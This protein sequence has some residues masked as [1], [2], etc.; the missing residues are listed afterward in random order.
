MQ[1]TVKKLLKNEFNSYKSVNQLVSHTTIGLP[2]TNLASNDPKSRRFGDKATCIDL[3]RLVI[4]N[5]NGDHRD[6]V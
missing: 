3:E 6:N 4:S 2:E 1:T 5:K